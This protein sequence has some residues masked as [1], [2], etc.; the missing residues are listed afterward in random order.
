MV[1]GHGAF[2]GAF[3]GAFEMKIIITQ[4]MKISVSILQCKI[5]Q[6]RIPQLSTTRNRDG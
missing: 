1:N 4:I 6:I 2:N 5:R 3:N